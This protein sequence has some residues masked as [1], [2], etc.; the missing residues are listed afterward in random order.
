MA[1]SEGVEL[2][3][4]VVVV[5]QRLAVA[6]RIEQVNELRRQIDDVRAVRRGDLTQILRRF[7]GHAG[8]GLADF[9]RQLGDPAAKGRPRFDVL[10]DEARDLVARAAKSALGPLERERRLQRDEV[11]EPGRLRG[12]GAARELPTLAQLRERRRLA[13]DDAAALRVTP[14]D[15]GLTKTAGVTR[16]A[17]RQQV[18][19]SGAVE[20]VDLRWLP[21][22]SQWRHQR[23]VTDREPALEL[24]I[25][26]GAPAAA[27]RRRNRNGLDA[28]GGDALGFVLR[29]PAFEH[30]PFEAARGV[31]Q[32]D[33]RPRLETRPCG[34]LRLGLR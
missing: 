8:L 34:V 3:Q 26:P 28:F 25:E 6:A 23:V 14:Q 7:L 19:E 1:L 22:D 18:A 4:L 21:C 20:A 31:E 5:V 27:A 24:G 12:V 9:A 15:P 29:D 10:A 2:A 17:A 30:T 13:R 32:K 11:R 33:D 16:I